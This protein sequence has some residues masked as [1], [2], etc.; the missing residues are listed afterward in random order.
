MPGLN[1]IEGLASNLNTTDIINATIM[2][3][4]R[5]AVLMERRQAEITKEISTFNALSAKLLALET[6]IKALNSRTK[7]SQASILVS[8]ESL[9]TATASQSCLLRED[10]SKSLTVL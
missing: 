9:L 8:N 1:S 2:Y 6:S 3:E 5:P 4:R 7:F 10:I